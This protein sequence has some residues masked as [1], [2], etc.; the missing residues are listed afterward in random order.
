MY[1]VVLTKNGEY[2]K[3]LYRSRTREASFVRFRKLKEENKSVIFP[4]KN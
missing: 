3:T 4:K 2:K 1:R